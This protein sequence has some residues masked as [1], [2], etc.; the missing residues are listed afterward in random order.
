MGGGECRSV[1]SIRKALVECHLTQLSIFNRG[2]RENS[3]S[4][5][6]TRMQVIER[7]WAAISISREPIGVPFFLRPAWY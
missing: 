7:A 1:R 2:I 3:F 6:V 4:L 5:F